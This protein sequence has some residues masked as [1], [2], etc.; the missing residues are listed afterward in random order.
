M[1]PA[2]ERARLALIQYLG[3]SDP[4]R[5][6]ELR[7]LITDNT[8]QA[9]EALDEAL[10]ANYGKFG[11][12]DMDEQFRKIDTAWRAFV[13]TR[14]DEL[15]PAADRGQLAVAQAL[16]N[17][18]QAERYGEFSGLMAKLIADEQAE[19]AAQTAKIAALRR[20]S[21]VLL[22]GISLLSI[23]AGAVVA[24]LISRGIVRVLK[25][26]D[27][28]TSTLVT[29][30]LTVRVP[31]TTR[32]E[33]GRLA[34]SINGFVDQLET[35]IGQ[36]VAGSQTIQREAGEIAGGAGSVSEGAQNQ[37]AT[38]EEIAASV[39]EL[40][41][42][43]SEV[44]KNA[45]AARALAATAVRQAGEGGQAVNSSIEATKQISRSSEQITEIIGSISEI[46]DQTNLLALNAAI[47]A[48][49]AG[50]HGMGFAVVADEVRKLA[51][52]SAQAARETAKLISESTGKAQEGARLTETA[53][54]VLAGIIGGVNQTAAAVGLDRASGGDRRRSRQVHPERRGGYRGEF[55]RG[56]RHRR[57]DPHPAGRNRAAAVAG[58]PVQDRR[59]HR[60]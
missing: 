16:A 23:I 5:K 38:I 19:A 9:D 26:I 2:M 34:E 31:V 40:T 53:G 29:G 35:T 32:D 22:I 52:R 17:G 28:A 36:L 45:Q 37:A 59:R 20:R 10:A 30:D 48:A 39:E 50:E 7:A 60:H 14:E 21:S 25:D 58:W 57:F 55:R 13:K 41:T 8:R 44:A 51:E 56:D 4:A 54:Q 18:V 42:S 1:A 12:A 15:I 33:F 43:I 47:E 24:W 27:E 6:T 46:A 49:R 11:D 3:A